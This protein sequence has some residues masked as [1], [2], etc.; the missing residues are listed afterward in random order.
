MATKSRHRRVTF[1]K[2]QVEKILN[3]AIL[4][5]QLSYLLA[6]LGKE[7]I[8]ETLSVTIVTAVIGVMLG[9]FLKSYFETREEERLNLDKERLRNSGTIAFEEETAWTNAEME[10]NETWQNSRF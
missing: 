6:F 5:M 3:F 2:R 7:Q 1:S 10:G 8:A 9:Y 4:D